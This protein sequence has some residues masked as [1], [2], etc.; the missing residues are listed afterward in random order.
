MR[1]AESRKQEKYE[2]VRGQL[3]IFFRNSILMRGEASEKEGG[4]CRSS[5][6]WLAEA[7]HSV[8]AFNVAVKEDKHACRE[9]KHPAQCRYNSL[10]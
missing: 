1:R 9:E 5:C 10:G 2:K 4:M 6:R 3:K 7:F 8:Q